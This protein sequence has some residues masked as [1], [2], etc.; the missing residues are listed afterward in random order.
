MNGKFMI[1]DNIPVEINGEKNILELVR[2][3]GIDLP[4]FCYYSE[5]SVY[6][7]CRMCMV[8]NKWGDME[9]ACSTPP[10][11]GMEIHTNTPRLRKYRKMNLEL[12]LSNH[13]RDCTTCEKN[14][15]CKL[16][17]LAQRFGIM[18]IRFENTFENREIDNSSLCI[19][20]DKSKCILCGDC[21]RVCDE[22]QNVGAIDF[23]KRGSK[24]SVGTAFD[25]PLSESNCVGCGQCAAV[26]PTGAIVVK[27]DTARLWEDISDKD[28][29]VVV[30]IAPA[31]RVGISQELGQ[32]DGENV[33]GKIVSALRKMGFDEVFDT[34][35]GADLTVLEETTEFLS[36]LEKNEKLPLFTSCCPAWVNYVENTYPSLLKN[37]STCRSPMQ[38]F[39]SVLKEHY[40]HSNK[41]IVSVAIMPCTAKKSEAKRNEFTEDGVSSVD[42]VITTQELIQMIKESG[43]VFSEVEPEAVD[44]P[45]GVSSG[46]G[47]IFGVTGGVTEA[48][49]RRVL[50]DKSTST[51]RALAFNGVRGM[52]GVKE[53]SIT[54]DNRVINIA[55]V[56]G[57]KNADD[58]VKRIEAGEAHYDFVEVMACPGGCI[59]GAGQPFAKTEGKLK[60]GAGL[61][62]ADRMSSIKRSEENPV[63]MSLYQGILKGKVHKLLHV[64]YKGKE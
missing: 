18:K 57:L 62:E 1:I 29:K 38:M 41:R 63:M 2:K 51:L 15:H 42:Y 60:R 54:V 39:S 10:R 50:D 53:T 23:V 12:L 40:K 24:M 45:F 11:D 32:K 3:A 61:Y 20:R 17:D 43:I 4:T 49:I 9:A 36:R 27:N 34:S 21:V 13:C 19:V 56:S 46:A 48:V 58:L 5:L 35:T 44:M 31:V 52:E 7:A 30:Q 8:E 64:E 22:V 59:S 55:V 25:E 33:M 47:V 37:V 14:G 28:T 16:Q 26:C 6:G